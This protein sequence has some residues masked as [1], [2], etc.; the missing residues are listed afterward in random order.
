MKKFVLVA[1]LAFVFAIGVAVG[2]PYYYE[3]PTDDQPGPVLAVSWEKW[4]ASA[5]CVKS[6]GTQS[7]VVTNN[8]VFSI[9][10]YEGATFPVGDYPL[11]GKVSTVSG[12][13]SWEG[14]AVA[15]DNQHDLAFVVVPAV[16]AASPLAVKN[17]PPGTDVW[18]KGMGAKGAYTFGK[19]L[20]LTTQTVFVSNLRSIP[21]DSGAGIFG[22]T[23]DVVAVNC[24]RISWSIDAP[25]RGTP[26]ET[27]REVLERLK[28]AI[29]EGLRP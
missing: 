3:I 18:H 26:A 29:P 11:K 10:P 5:V 14:I 8:H 17:A 22:P 6:D 13:T 1:I 15:G 25:E 19:V 7:L 12:K 20:D 9:Q 24:G 21:G 23:G 28:T 4:S 27:I 16:L 2:Q